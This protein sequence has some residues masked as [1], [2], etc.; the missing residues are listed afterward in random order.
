MT[1]V[2]EAISN[3]K[4]TALWQSQF[5]VMCEAFLKSKMKMYQVLNIF[6]IILEIEGG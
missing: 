1:Y 6:Q 3:M 4:G 2:R 5:L